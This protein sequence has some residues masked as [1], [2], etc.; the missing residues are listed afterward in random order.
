MH[1]V[2]SCESCYMT[3]F[4][5]PD[6]VEMSDEEETEDEEPF[7]DDE[8]SEQSSLR[9]TTTTPTP[10]KRARIDSIINI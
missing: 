2:R 10:A 1:Y 3:K 8:N 7:I 6:S 9:D 5:D 4:K